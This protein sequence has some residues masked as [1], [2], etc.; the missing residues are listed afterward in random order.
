MATTARGNDTREG[1]I[2]LMP[3][4]LAAVATATEPLITISPAKK[5]RAG[6]ANQ[7]AEHENQR[8]TEKRHGK[9][10]GK[11][12]KCQ[13]INETRPRLDKEQGATRVWSGKPGRESETKT[14]M[15]KRMR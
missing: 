9:K 8:R 6:I 4:T 3:R 13:E 1:A 15:E 11:R 12:L 14:G 10:N 2:S 5:I 7:R